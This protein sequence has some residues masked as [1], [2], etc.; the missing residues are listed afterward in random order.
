[1]AGKIPKNLRKLEANAT[2][3][4]PDIKLDPKKL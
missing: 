2:N 1:M 3:F 4:E